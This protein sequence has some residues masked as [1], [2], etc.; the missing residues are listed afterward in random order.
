[1]SSYYSLYKIRTPGTLQ[2][3]KLAS[4]LSQRAARHPVSVHQ[5]GAGGERSVLRQLGPD[6]AGCP[7]S[8]SAAKRSPGLE[9]E[10][11]RTGRGEHLSAEHMVAL[12]GPGWALQ[13][14]KAIMA[15]KSLVLSSLLVLGLLVLG[16]PS[17]PGLE[18]PA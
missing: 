15:L 18:F 10:Q 9:K 17:P 16:A 7:Q 1:T 3:Q 4:P 8:V 13:R 14:S 11:P 2:Y 12:L 6:R 5:E